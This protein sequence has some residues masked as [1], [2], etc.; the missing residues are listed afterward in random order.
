MSATR[1][2]TD[3]QQVGGFGT[4]DDKGRLSLPKQVRE[5]LG[6]QPGASMAYIVLDGAVLLVPQ[7]AHLT[8]LMERAAQ[9][10]G[11][12]HVTVRDLLDELP[13]AR[14]DVVREAYGEEFMR[15]LAE[16]HQ[17]FQRAESGK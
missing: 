2:T 1:H 7:D 12:A 4:L 3:G 16:Q 11:K 9:V 13:Q 10:L 6:V 5:S 17:V 8:A 15:E 14:A